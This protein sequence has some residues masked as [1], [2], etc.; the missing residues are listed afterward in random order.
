LWSAT[1]GG[2]NWLRH[3]RALKTRGIWICGQPPAVGPTATCGGANWLRHVRALKTR[4]IW[5]CGQWSE[6]TFQVHCNK[7]STGEK[8]VCPARR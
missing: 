6:R 4:G 8:T 3:V 1:C 5:I 7:A 2:A